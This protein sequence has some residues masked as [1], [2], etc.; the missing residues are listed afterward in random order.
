VL[1]S[2]WR[3]SSRSKKVGTTHKEV[4]LPKRKLLA[5]VDDDEEFREALATL[6][7]AIGFEVDEYR[8]GSDFLASSKTTAAACLITDVQMPG[9]T[10]I[11]LYRRMAEIGNATPTIMITAYPDEA[12]KAR[13]L[14]DGVVC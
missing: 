11:Q 8:S 2:A 1:H 5:I 14:M 12:V 13:M 6:L 3:A 10:G 4:R 7:R 9:M